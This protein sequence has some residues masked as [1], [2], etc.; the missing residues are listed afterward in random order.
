MQD[1]YNSQTATSSASSETNK[2]LRNTYALLAMT[3]LFSA[4]TASITMAI[5]LGHGAALI[6]MLAAL[7]IVW[8]VLP[9]TA[10]SGAGIFVVFAFTGLLGG[11][12]GPMLN[13]Y[14]S[15]ANGGSIVMQ[16]L[17]GTALVFF[18]LSAYVLTTRK[19][20]SFMGGFLATGL[21]VAIVAMI[22]MF[23]AS[24]F[25]IAVSGFSLAISGLVVLLMSGFILYDTSR[26]INGGETNYLMATT[27]LYLNIYNL[28]TSLLHILGV[29]GDD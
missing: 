29:M 1:I 9:R 5:G 3:L 12:L 7:A 25:G 26:I 13:Y 28:F 2:V 20:F 23:V 15:M 24:M 14:L 8:F 21:I 4:V 10:N 19:D 17:G 18:S 22:G 6:M 16:A 11:A 27:S